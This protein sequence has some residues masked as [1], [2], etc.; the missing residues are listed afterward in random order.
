MGRRVTCACTLHAHVHVHVARV[1]GP[2]SAGPVFVA[3]MPSR[4]HGGSMHAR[5]DSIHVH[6]DGHVPCGDH[7]QHERSHDDMLRWRWSL[8]ECH[9]TTA[10]ARRGP[11][12]ESSYMG[13]GAGVGRSQ[14][15][16]AQDFEYTF[17]GHD[18]RAGAG[19]KRRAYMRA[20]HQM[21]HQSS[22]SRVAHV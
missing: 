20:W 17:S 5:L 2:R 11:P 18:S 3:C 16:S 7:R 19:E 15:L 22:G 13:C 21:H 8:C 1:C 10:W 4:W 14:I 12:F 6:L 9:G